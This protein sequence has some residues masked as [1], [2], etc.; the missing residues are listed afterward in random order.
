MILDVPTQFTE[1]IRSFGYDPV[2]SGEWCPQ[3][4]RQGQI[5]TAT[6][7]HIPASLNPRFYF[8]NVFFQIIL[9]TEQ[10]RMRPSWQIKLESVFALFVLSPRATAF[11]HDFASR[12]GVFIPSKKS[13]LKCED[14]VK[15][16]R[17]YSNR[18]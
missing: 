14:N 16:N 13:S 15:I 4:H 17:K 3:C 12:P 7:H 5:Y 10:W 11:R 18:M 9:K 1:G 8:L 6:Q 2:S